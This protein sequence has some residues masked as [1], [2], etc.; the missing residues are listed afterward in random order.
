[1]HRAGSENFV[2]MKTGS[3]GRASSVTPTYYPASFDQIGTV[4][5]PRAMV[6]KAPSPA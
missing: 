1:V 6:S 4:V 2:V 3:T 5:R